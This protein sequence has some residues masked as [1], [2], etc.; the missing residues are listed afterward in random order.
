M[1]GEQNESACMS[2]I[3]SRLKYL[4]K[5]L[6]D[7]HN[8]YTLKCVNMSRGVSLHKSIMKPFV[9]PEVLH[10][11][12]VGLIMGSLIKINTAETEIS[13]YLFHASF[14]HF[15]IWRLHYP[16]YSLATE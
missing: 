13:P 16:Q 7:C 14:L 15:K 5:Y 9:S 1:V 8:F 10:Y 12:I 4:N 6:M 3:W 11:K 2:T